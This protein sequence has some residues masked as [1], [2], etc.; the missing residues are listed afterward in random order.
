MEGSDH[1]L[2]DLEHGN[3]THRNNT[4]LT[5]Q[6]IKYLVVFGV[7]VMGIMYAVNRSGQKSPVRVRIPAE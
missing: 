2:S 3:L 6:E 4:F 5:G 7:I 1:K